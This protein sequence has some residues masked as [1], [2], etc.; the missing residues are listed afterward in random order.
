MDSLK[1]P[2]DLDLEVFELSSEGEE[3]REIEG[4][5]VTLV[6]NKWHST[7]STYPL[8]EIDAEGSS[9]SAP[10]TIVIF[11]ALVSSVFAALRTAVSVS[12]LTI[13]S[14]CA[15]YVLITITAPLRSCSVAISIF[16]TLLKAVICLSELVYTTVAAVTV[17]FPL[18]LCSVFAWS[19]CAIL[20]V[21]VRTFIF[22]LKLPYRIPRLIIVI[23]VRVCC[24]AFSVVY[25]LMKAA[26]G[27]SELVYGTINMVTITV[28]LRL[29]RVII[30]GVHV[31]SH[32][33]VCATV[34]GV[35][36]LFSILH[37]IRRTG[38]RVTRDMIFIARRVL[39]PR[40]RSKK[41]H[42]YTRFVI[43]R[44]LRVKD[45]DQCLCVNSLVP[46]TAQ[47]SIMPTSNITQT[48]GG[49]VVS[50]TCTALV[51]W[52]PNTTA[53]VQAK[54]IKLIVVLR[55]GEDD[56]FGRRGLDVKSL[57]EGSNSSQIVVR[58][59]SVTPTATELAHL[60]QLI[61][62]TLRTARY[63]KSGGSARCRISCASGQRT[64]FCQVPT[65]SE[66]FL[67]KGKSDVK[68]ASI[69]G[70]SSR[71]GFLITP[72][73]ALRIIAR[74]T[75]LRCL[76]VVAQVF[77]PFQESVSRVTQTTLN[78][79]RNPD[80]QHHYQSNTMAGML[81]NVD[82]GPRSVQKHKCADVVNT[83]QNTVRNR[84]AY[85]P[86]IDIEGDGNDHKNKPSMKTAAVSD[87]PHMLSSRGTQRRKPIVASFSE[88]GSEH[89]LTNNSRHSYASSNYTLKAR[90]RRRRNMKS[91]G[92]E[93]TKEEPGLVTPKAYEAFKR[94]LNDC[95]EQSELLACD[96]DV[97]S[98]ANVKENG[99][100][101]CSSDVKGIH[102]NSAEAKHITGQL[103]SDLAD[104]D[105]KDQNR[106]E[107]LPSRFT[108]DS[109]DCVKDYR[110]TKHLMGTAPVSDH[111]TT[112]A[113]ES[114]LD[115]RRDQG[116]A[117]SDANI[118]QEAETSASE[119]E[120]HIARD[121]YEPDKFSRRDSQHKTT[122][123]VSSSERH[124]EHSLI[125]SSN[126]S[127]TQ[128][129]SKNTLVARSR[130][131][132]HARSTGDEET[133]KET[134]LVTPEAYEAFK[135]LLNDCFNT[136]S[137]QVAS[138]QNK[139][140]A[141]MGNKH[142]NIKGLQDAYTVVSAG[143]ITTSLKSKTAK[144]SPRQ[145][146]TATSL[147][148]SAPKIAATFSRLSTVKPSPKPNIAAT[149]LK[150]SAVKPPSRLNNAATSSKS[151]TVKPTPRLGIEHHSKPCAVCPTQK[152]N[153]I[154]LSKTESYAEVKG[155]R[156]AETYA[157]FRQIY[158]GIP[159]KYKPRC[160]EAVYRSPDPRH[161]SRLPGGITGD[162]R[163]GNVLEYRNCEMTTAVK[164]TKVK[165][166][167][168]N[169]N[170]DLSLLKDAE[171]P[172]GTWLARCKLY[173]RAREKRF[174]PTCDSI[175]RS[176][177]RAPYDFTEH[178]GQTS[179]HNDNSNSVE[180]QCKPISRPICSL[181]GADTV[182]GDTATPKQSIIIDEHLLAQNGTVAEDQGQFNQ[183]QVHSQ[184]SA[185]QV[186]SKSGQRDGQ[187]SQ[188]Q[189]HFNPG[190]VQ[191]QISQCEVKDQFCQGYVEGEGDVSSK[192]QG[193]DIEQNTGVSQQ[194]MKFFTI[195]NISSTLRSTNEKTRTSLENNQRID[196]TPAPVCQSSTLDAVTESM[197]VPTPK[198]TDTNMEEPEDPDYIHCIMLA[199][200]REKEDV[201]KTAMDKVRQLV[202]EDKH[203]VN[204]G[205]ARESPVAVKSLD[206][207]E[208]YNASGVTIVKVTAI[209]DEHTQGKKYKTKVMKNVSIQVAE[210]VVKDRVLAAE[211]DKDVITQGQMKP[212]GVVNEV[213]LLPANWAKG[214]SVV[215]ATQNSPKP[216]TRLDIEPPLLS[217]AQPR[218]MPNIAKTSEKSFPRL[219]AVASL[220]ATVSALLEQNSIR[221]PIDLTSPI[222]RKRKHSAITKDNEVQDEPC[223]KWSNHYRKIKTLPR[224]TTRA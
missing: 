25:L 114:H 11:M 102:E 117:R 62:T 182:K 112:V 193:T 186:Q 29:F 15:L 146:I 60:A 131:R 90:S 5:P 69:Q 22:G 8:N 98:S 206:L 79:I 178:K 32:V 57:A 54:K 55:M 91:T 207:G 99:Y 187:E 133:E 175:A 158:N 72:V 157:R 195:N 78:I 145:N 120:Q 12:F 148:S 58:R 126:H 39:P 14:A 48:R 221:S 196:I 43:E 140:N 1:T 218:Q 118:L 183:D 149:S 65:T 9:R 7:T 2:Q 6:D 137:E 150:S 84:A 224:L 161:E 77:V 93:E 139:S 81:G 155:N 119:G 147:K 192:K 74:L 156:Q 220:N 96:P 141:D 100:F 27:V 176:I 35:Q 144:H 190:H 208:R 71:Q 13:K 167:C 171:E 122:A 191:G 113:P 210:K 143:G 34:Y 16:L 160:D 168:N 136:Q 164:C 172:F 214:Q 152:T 66:A 108:S 197:T 50:S 198:N 111:H 222:R 123:V 135:R 41:T 165:C 169:G 162:G 199:R 142:A 212:Y 110:K 86:T 45:P 151:N 33:T 106:V 170:E 189:S 19:V 153:V 216:L 194:D 10:W 28:P 97:T 115:Q 36:L 24:A 107:S 217:T 61:Q 202:E 103:I 124:G 174:P 31:S 127:Y 49:S 85:Q 82:R 80:S 52:L 37:G 129:N 101:K 211:R 205:T 109:E 40:P 51:T 163:L 154:T 38:S 134:G 46:T 83:E 121:V 223:A 116:V 201:C 130:R 180:P 3:T 47:T 200:G 203:F 44:P 59:S 94:L 21:A 92:E 56:V 67:K 173:R 26:I 185:G 20:R 23:L 138:D 30:W 159:F 88:K 68:K 204:G 213:V 87:Q 73:N 188:V 181:H 132:S 166:S 184:F 125:N 89:T 177:V 42:T 64:P 53:P 105:R 209:H 17:T 215:P 18:R 76:S 4:S 63:N 179:S 75:Q 70:T 219:D 128:S 104:T 95:F